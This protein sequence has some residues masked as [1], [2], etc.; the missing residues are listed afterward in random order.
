[1]VLFLLSLCRNRGCLRCCQRRVECDQGRPSCQRC[2]NRDEICEGYRDEASIIF[3]HETDKITVRVHAATVLSPPDTARRKGRQMSNRLKST[4][5]DAA[6]D[7]FVEKYVVHPCNETSSPGFLEHLPSL[8]KDAN[9]KGRFALRYYGM[10]LSALHRSLSI[11]GKVLDDHDLVTITFLVPDPTSRGAHAQGVAQ[12]LRLRGHDQVYNARSWSLF[13]LIHHRIQKQQLAFGL[14]SLDVSGDWIG[15]SNDD[16]PF[17]RLEKDAFHVSR[18]CDRARALQRALDNDELPVA[19]MLGLHAWAFK[20]L[21]AHDLPSYKHSIQSFTDTIQLHTDLWMAYEWNYHGTARMIA[22]EQILKCLNTA[23]VSLNLDNATID[24]LCALSQD[25]TSIIHTLADEILSTMSQYLGDI[26]HLGRPREVQSGPLR[27][28]GIREYLW[29]RPI[30]QK[31][32]TVFERIQEY[33]A[34][35]ISR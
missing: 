27:C 14:N 33:G 17:V 34:E 7:H 18:T 21:A 11:Q 4:P 28:R 35:D 6:V 32:Q 29:L 31:S 15:P 23:L 13:R 20:T 12:I 16:M 2:I 30:K 8:F 3:W 22:H 9:M 25:S 24:T 5:E 26:D 1:M 10:S 19:E